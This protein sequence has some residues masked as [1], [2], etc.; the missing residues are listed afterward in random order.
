MI[1]LVEVTLLTTASVMAI[2]I[3]LYFF[4]LKRSRCVKN[5][6]SHTLS[7]SFTGV[8]HLYSTFRTDKMS[9]QQLTRKIYHGGHHGD[10]QWEFSE[11]KL[12]YVCKYSELIFNITMSLQYIEI[13]WIFWHPSGN[14]QTYLRASLQKKVEPKL[15]FI[16]IFCYD[17]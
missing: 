17:H 8:S 7:Y 2:Q 16:K 5:L 9:P 1:Q 12:I 3:D 4:T 15:G 14:W 11:W 10:S 6:M 13:F